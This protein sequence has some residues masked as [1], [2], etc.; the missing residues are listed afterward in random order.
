MQERNLDPGPRPGNTRASLGHWETYYRTGALVTCPMGHVSGYTLELHDVWKDFF[1][2]LADGARILDVATGN[3]AIALMAKETANALGRQYEVH[4]ADLAQIDPARDVRDG[5]RL[6]AD[7]RF[8]ARVPMERLP[9]PPETFDAVSGQYAL[10]YAAV[11][12]A[13]AEIFRVLKGSGRAQFVIHHA[14]SIILQ[15]A[16][17]SL[18]HADLVLN[19]TKVFRRL[20]R[21]LEAEHRSRTAARGPREALVAAMTSLQKAAA[22]AGS[23]LTLSVTLDA[24]QKLLNA[25]RQLSR[26]SMD[27]Q[28]DQIEGDIRASARRLQDLVAS[29]Q[30]AEGIARIKRMAETLGFIEC[31]VRPQYHAGT[32][33][34]GWRLNLRKP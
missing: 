31:D 26:A 1:A 18:V 15:S 8:H 10:E 11:D 9:F 29:A 2:G 27:R 23:A 7:I 25:R 17:E 14:E 20:R 6:F 33:L 22:N 19:D 3:G 16:R 5:A 12:A 24:V 4:G 30:S 28:I 32:N 34:V 21:Y 13:S